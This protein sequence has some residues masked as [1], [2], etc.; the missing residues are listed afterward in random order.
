M[1]MRVGFRQHRLKGLQEELDRITA[2]LPQLGV[3][4]AILLNPLD[5]DMVQPDTHLKFA[6]EFDVD[7][8]FVRRMDFFYSHLLP[9]LGV[10]FL[11]YTPNEFLL[12]ESGESSL[13]KEIRRGRVVL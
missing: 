1:P 2:A 11:V 5:L 12:I 6:L 9:R 8:P 10:D 3:T 4:R 7:W 13:S